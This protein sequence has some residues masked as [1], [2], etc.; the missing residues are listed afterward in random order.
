MPCSLALG[1]IKD[2]FSHNFHLLLHLLRNDAR[3][4]NVY[5]VSLWIILR[6]VIDRSGY[7]TTLQ[8]K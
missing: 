1:N 4:E 7:Q 5:I 8:K 2:E 3:T 6:L